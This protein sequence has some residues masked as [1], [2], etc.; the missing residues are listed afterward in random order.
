MYPGKSE[1][2]RTYD[3]SAKQAKAYNGHKMCER[4]KNNTFSQS[5]QDCLMNGPRTYR[6]IIN[7]YSQ[8]KEKKTKFLGFFISI[9]STIALHSYII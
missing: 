6:R 1:R 5:R 9:S 8:G 7:T 3:V 4:C 2:K